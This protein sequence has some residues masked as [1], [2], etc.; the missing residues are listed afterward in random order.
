MSQYS[1]RQTG[2]DTVQFSVEEMP[3]SD[4]N[5]DIEKGIG[6]TMLMPV[7]IPPQRYSG[8]ESSDVDRPGMIGDSTG[9][10]TWYY[11]GVA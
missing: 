9:P 8:G 3:D 10:C 2:R 4:M 1:T 5:L 6:V 11:S 7:Y